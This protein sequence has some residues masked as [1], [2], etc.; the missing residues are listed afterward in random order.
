M[1]FLW[2]YRYFIHSVRFYF[3]VHLTL[4]VKRVKRL[5]TIYLCG[6][7]ESRAVGFSV[8]LAEKKFKADTETEMNIIQAAID[9]NICTVKYLRELSVSSSQSMLYYVCRN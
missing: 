5:F 4:W 6:V 7:N 2:G 9:C 8:S 3:F 1:N